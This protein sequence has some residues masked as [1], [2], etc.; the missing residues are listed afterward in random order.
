MPMAPLLLALGLAAAPPPD[1]TEAQLREASA[2][3]AETW[4]PFCPGH[5]LSTCTSG[6]AAQW[7]GDIRVWLAE[8]LTRDQIMARLQ[9]R[10]PQFSLDTVPDTGGARYG[11]WVL[12]GAFALI[13]G[14]LAWATARRSREPDPA[15]PAAPPREGEDARRLARELEAI[16]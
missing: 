6:K 13:L 4:S 15:P 7:R 10:V 12:G 9:A 14:G 11:P 3:F 5:T 1:L 16:D 2:I 8:G